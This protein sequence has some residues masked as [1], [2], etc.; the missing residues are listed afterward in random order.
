MHL[1]AHPQFHPNRRG[2]QHYF[3]A[4]GGGHI[5]LPG[6]KGGPEYL[7]PLDRNGQDEPL[8]GYLTSLFGREA[9]TFIRK[10]H[11]QPWF[12]YLAFNAPHTP[13]QSTP[14]LQA[15]VAS[16]PDPARRD[17]AA[18]IVGLDDAIGMSF[19]R[20]RNRNSMKTRS[21]FLK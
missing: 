14:E 1:G 4:L 5:Y 3:G 21:S 16:I 10:K 9:S 2:F 20:S 18:M 7:I 12:L 8:E 11:N 19:R 17:L 6:L 15:R 13:L